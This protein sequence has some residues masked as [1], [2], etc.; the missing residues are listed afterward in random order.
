MIISIH[1][2]KI[3]DE[4]QHPFW[5]KVLI[6]LEIEATYLNIIKVMHDKPIAN[7]IQNGQNIKHFLQSQK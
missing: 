6:K 2:E 5:I 3:F 1:T 4:V 7:I